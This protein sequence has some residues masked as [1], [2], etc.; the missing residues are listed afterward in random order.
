MAQIGCGQYF[1]RVHVGSLEQM[2]GRVA[3]V[4]EVGFIE[5]G[6][7]KISKREDTS[8]GNVYV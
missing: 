2:G 1:K 7:N 5:S 6:L 3:E 8:S 4:R